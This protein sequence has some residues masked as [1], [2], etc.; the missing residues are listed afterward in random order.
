MGQGEI[1]GVKRRGEAEG[2]H[3]QFHMRD[4]EECRMAIYRAERKNEVA[5]KQTGSKMNI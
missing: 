4:K 3:W 1:K 5:A 2:E